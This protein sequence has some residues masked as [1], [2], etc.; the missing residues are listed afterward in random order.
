MSRICYRVPVSDLLIQDVTRYIE[1]Q[2]PVE[3]V[4]HFAS[5][6]SPPNYLK[7]PIQTLKVGALGG[8]PQ[9]TPAGH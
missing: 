1:V 6:A 8:R 9:A 2:G 4:L 5:P 3:A 7:F